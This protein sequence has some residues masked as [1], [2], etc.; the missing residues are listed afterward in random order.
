[1]EKLDKLKLIQTY[2][3]KLDSDFNVSS[4]TEI[5]DH[6]RDFESDD[7]EIDDINKIYDELEIELEY[8]DDPDTIY[9]SREEFEMYMNEIDSFEEVDKSTV[10][11]THFRQT[12]ISSD[13]IGWSAVM[14]RIMSFKFVAKGYSVTVIDKP[15]LIGL[16]NSKNKNYDE[17]CGMYPCSSYIALELKYESDSFL[18]RKEED[19]LFERILYYISQKIGCAVYVS[20]S[21]DVCS[22][23][24]DLY[25][26]EESNEEEIVGVESLLSYS[27]LTRLYSQALQAV[28]NEIR[29]LYFYKII[30]HISPVVAKLKA[31]NELNKRL[32][33]L[34]SSKRDYKYLDSIFDICRKYDKEVKDD[35]L[36]ASVLQECIDV[37]SL[38]GYLPESKVKSYKSNLKLTLSKD[39]MPTDKNFSEEQLHSYQNQLAKSLYATRN[40][41]VHAKSNYEPTGSEFSPGEMQEA[42]K[43]MEIIATS[44]I[45]W[46][47]RQ[48]DAY[49]IKE[50]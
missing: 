38:W 43:I 44:I 35:F 26:C 21:I 37:V 9:Y 18:E 15:L 17:D 48:S 30:E 25:E 46:N 3:D 27:P 6:I 12:V 2:L 39:E 45:Q 42:N 8:P 16:A 33:V 34:A 40:S 31:Y 11:T 19:A 10:R 23:S 13:R 5:E 49:K 50:S 24:Y 7:I 32:D 28:D 4:P 20:E 36:C 22:L 1:M 29:F 41:I 14:D 47:E